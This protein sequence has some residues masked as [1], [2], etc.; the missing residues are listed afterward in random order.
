MLADSDVEFRQMQEVGAEAEAVVEHNGAAGEVEVGLG[1][2]DD[3]GSGRVNGCALGTAMSMP[4][5][6]AFGSPL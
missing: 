6:G 3:A 2:S 1:E 4:E 5:C